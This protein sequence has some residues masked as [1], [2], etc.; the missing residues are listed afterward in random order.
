MVIDDLLDHTINV[1]IGC[2]FTLSDA[3]VQSS[4][5]SKKQRRLPRQRM[6]TLLNVMRLWFYNTTLL[7]RHLDIQ[8]GGGEQRQ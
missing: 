8:I 7:Q 3:L 5:E 1:R 2:Y 6:P 4:S